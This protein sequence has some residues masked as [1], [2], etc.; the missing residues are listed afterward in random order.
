M[1][2]EAHLTTNRLFSALAGS[3][4][5]PSSQAQC[6]YEQEGMSPQRVSA[7]TSLWLIMFSKVPLQE[8]PNGSVNVGAS[9]PRPIRPLPRPRTAIAAAAA[10]PPPPSP[11][12]PPPAHT[13]PV[14]PSKNRRLAAYDEDEEEDDLYEIDGQPQPVGPAEEDLGD[15]WGDDDNEQPV[16]TASGQQDDAGPEEDDADN[17][18]D[19]ANNDAD[20][21]G[22]D[23]PVEAIGGKRKRSGASTAPK[24]RAK[25]ANF[26][27][28]TAAVI[29]IGQT[30]CRCKA[31][32]EDP[33]ANA[34][35]RVAI[36]DESWDAARTGTSSIIQPDA[37]VHANAIVSC[38]VEMEHELT[39]LLP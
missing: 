21:E 26:D 30:I 12:P 5:R 39:N 37:D 27:A 38:S 25:A 3:G 15:T 7:L 2:S 23:E 34:Q 24:K 33:F 13:A 22:D 36:A 20:D 35:S 9:N 14:S 29:L 16:S 32:S 1:S 18:A 31:V 6:R 11:S 17:D 10:P 19:D 4:Q 8:L 28:G